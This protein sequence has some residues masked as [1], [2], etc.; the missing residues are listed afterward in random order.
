LEAPEKF[1]NF[2]YKIFY[3][4]NILSYVAQA[5]RKLKEIFCLCKGATR[6]IDKSGKLGLAPATITFDNVCR[7]RKGSSS[8]LTRYPKGLLFGEVIS[9]FVYL[10][11]K[12]ISLLPD[13][14][15]FIF[16]HIRYY[17]TLLNYC[18]AALLR[19]SF[20]DCRA[21]SGCDVSVL[22]VC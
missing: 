12:L 19:C 3:Y 8:D 17:I 5:F 7:D 4:R 21:I 9:K 10:E 20:I 16:S 2:F 14:E 15:L 11:C 6:H 18:T 13:N 22:K 1:S